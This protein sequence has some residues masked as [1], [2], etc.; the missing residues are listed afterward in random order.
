MEKIYQWLG[1]FINKRWLPVIIVA[2]IMIVPAVFGALRISIESGTKTFMSTNSPAYRDRQKFAQYFSSDVI[3]ILIKAENLKQLLHPDSL[4]AIGEL[5]SKVAANPKISSVVGPVFLIKQ[6]MSFTTGKPVIPDDPRRITRMVV[7]RKT[8]LARALYKD[9]IPDDKHALIAVVANRGLDD[10]ELEAV[11][12]EVNAVVEQTPLGSMRAVVTGEPVVRVK[13]DDAITES[14]GQMLLVAFILMLV[15]LLVVFNVRNS[16]MWR[17]L[18]LVMVLISIVY[19]FGLMGLFGIPM[20]MVTIAAFPV[21]IGLGADY[22]IQFHNRYDEEARKGHTFSEAL[23]IAVTRIGPPIGIAILVACLG[24]AAL[25]FSPVPMVQSFGVTLIIGVISA[26]ILGFMFLMP[27]LYWNDQRKSEKQVEVKAQS[28]H[29]ADK[30]NLGFVERGLQLLAPRV[31][32]RPAVILPIALAAMLAGVIVDGKIEAES[33]PMKYMSKDLEVIKNILTLEEVFGGIA[34]ANV[35]IEAED[36]ASPDILN[37]M[38]QVQ[39]K[40]REKASDMV[41]GTNS[42]TNLV[43]QTTRGKIPETSEEV[44]K[45]LSPMPPEIKGNLVSNDFKA[46]NLSV[47]IK[48]LTGDELGELLNN[49]GEWI[50]GAP[51]GVRTTL[52]GEAVMHEQLIT[53]LTGGRL[54]M[55][56]IGF[57][58]V[59]AGLIVCF[60]FRPIRALMAV[61]PIGLILGWSALVMYSAGISYSPATATLGALIIGIGVEFTVLLMT[62]YYE[63]RRYG[64]KP[65]EAM[66]VA[67]TRIGRAI[68][69]SG[70][71][72]VGG[73]G[74]LLIARDF[75]VLQ[76]FGV[77]T[78]INI[79]FALVSTL[80]VLPPLIVWVDSWWARRSE[81]SA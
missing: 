45:S 35:L 16:F 81:A 36:V 56:L 11:V 59:F 15:I 26:Y 52:T 38:W 23:F 47:N 25:F 41:G 7:D 79:F 67:M 40:V 28:N 3:I 31:I 54:K 1:T 70:L 19:A 80:I 71:T 4:K 17:W 49:L 46:A 42:L 6:I 64:L 39:L 65:D 13:M 48:A 61:L 21:L 74:A 68:I 66:T 76:D 69:A 72:V 55:T 77:V 33:D 34:S 44:K 18:P 63:E 58:L 62:R 8:G 27:V 57:V 22:A 29:R 37:W 12:D 60:R 30:E 20:T 2:L 9:V 75:P 10:A 5:E 51:P 24:F 53:G 32:K 14:L 73:F 50:K 43:L 78:M